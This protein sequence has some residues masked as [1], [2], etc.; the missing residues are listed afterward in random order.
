MQTY[1][2]VWKQR[3]LGHFGDLKP[4]LA[5]PFW[6]PTV[7]TEQFLVIADLGTIQAQVCM[8]SAS[9]SHFLLAQP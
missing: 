3:P 1:P 6:G 9:S 4:L 7:Q 5:C 2:E 8:A